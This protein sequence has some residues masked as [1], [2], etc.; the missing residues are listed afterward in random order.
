MWLDRLDEMLKDV[1]DLTCV[2]WDGD[3]IQNLFG[4]RT[5]TARKIMMAVTRIKVP[6]KRDRVVTTDKLRSLLEQFEAHM[7]TCSDNKVPLSEAI[8]SA[9]LL[10]KAKIAE[11][12]EA[13]KQDADAP[14]SDFITVRI[15]RQLKVPLRLA[16]QKT[17]ETLRQWIEEAINDRLT[18]LA[19]EPTPVT[20]SS[21]ISDNPASVNRGALGN[22]RSIKPDDE[23]CPLPLDERTGLEAEPSGV[24]AKRQTRIKKAPRS[25]PPE[26]NLFSESTAS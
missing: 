14:L 6:G 25:Q 15:D 10:F 19:T 22:V 9:E 26:P 20:H 7:R 18:L 3:Q 21:K 1:N 24:L 12:K 11:A 4:V 2:I 23:Q 13:E 16:Q 8:K 17:G 5:G